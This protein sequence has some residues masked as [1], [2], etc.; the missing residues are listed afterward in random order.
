MIAV[1]CI[2]VRFQKVK[3]VM[4]KLIFIISDN[5]GSDIFKVLKYGQNV[6]GYSNWILSDQFVKSLY[7]NS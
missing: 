6:K 3:P 2:N 7:S 5:N 4:T 1:T